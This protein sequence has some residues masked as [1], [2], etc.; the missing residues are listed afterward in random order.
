MATD[1]HANANR[2]FEAM[3]KKAASGDEF[4]DV[5]RHAVNVAATQAGIIKY[6][7]AMAQVMAQAAL[8]SQQAVG[9]SPYTAIDK[10]IGVVRKR[11]YEL[12]EEKQGTAR[13]RIEKGVVID[14]E[15]PDALD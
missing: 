13:K 3:F 4:E 10:W 9:D 12:V 14:Q 7:E 6:M 11:A 8:A 1:Y 2:A 5:A 15:K